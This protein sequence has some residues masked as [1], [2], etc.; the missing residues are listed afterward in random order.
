MSDRV[1][2]VFF[3]LIAIVYGGLAG[4]YKSDFADPIG[5]EGFPF[6]VSLPMGLLSLALIIKPSVAADWPGG[7]A[8][9]KQAAVI[10]I[11]IAYA[12]A[13]EPVGFPLATF[14]AVIF[15]A[16]FLEATWRQCVLVGA[17]LAVL[18]YVVFDPLLG[19]PLPLGLL[20][21]R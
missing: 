11:L 3:L 13:L 4:N 6:F 16:R 5:T 9:L 1:A 17:I 21:L 10:L 8:L 15:L 20:E 12:A 14:V 18:L 7:K 2:G 19:L